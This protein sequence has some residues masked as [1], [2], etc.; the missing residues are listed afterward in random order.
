MD[1]D[2]HLDTST[3]IHARFSV[4]G[5]SKVFPSGVKGQWLFPGE[6]ETENLRGVVTIAHLA[7]P[8]IRQNTGKSRSFHSR[9]TQR[10][11]GTSPKPRILIGMQIDCLEM[12]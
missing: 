1:L 4:L 7:R 6:F 11:T 12:C 10:M 2:L 5:A 3:C 9:T 8:T